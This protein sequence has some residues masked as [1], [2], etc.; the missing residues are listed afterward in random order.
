[1]RIPW[2]NIIDVLSEGTTVNDENVI[3]AAINDA[4]IDKKNVI[5]LVNDQNPEIRMETTEVLSSDGRT[6]YQLTSLKHVKENKENGAK[7]EVQLSRSFSISQQISPDNIDYFNEAEVN[8]YE[9]NLPLG[10]SI[11]RQS[12]HVQG[13]FTCYL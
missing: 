6:L 10:T 9:N 4:S 8:A 5:K 1:M 11:S 13:K 3:N 12:G 2:K 7:R